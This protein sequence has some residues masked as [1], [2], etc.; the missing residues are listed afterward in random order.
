MFLGVK[1]RFSGKVG[2]GDMIENFKISRLT[3][4][5]LF[6]SIRTKFLVTITV[7]LPLLNLIMVAC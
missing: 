2:A 3:L 6:Y 5:Y 4:E 7:T 1:H